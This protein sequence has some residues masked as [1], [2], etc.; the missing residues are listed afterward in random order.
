MARSNK[1]IKKRKIVSDPVYGNKLI[2]KLINRI[3]RSGKKT[4]AQ[5]QVYRALEI[6]KTK[7]EADPLKTLENALNTL[8]PR[9]E[10]RPKRV[11]GASY[12][13][14]VEVRGDRRMTLAIRWLSEAAKKRSS[15]EYHTFAEKIAA[16]VLD[17]LKNQGE[18]IKKRDTVLRMAEAN[19]A[20]AHF[21]W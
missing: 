19:R 6:L 2:T 21:R 20:F 18:A 14:P 13:V 16:E 15:R 4:V 3:M 11:G 10:V 1:I 7:G 8:G 17:I 12:Q 9:M 5:T